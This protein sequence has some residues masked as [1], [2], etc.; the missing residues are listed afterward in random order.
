MISHI[1]PRPVTEFSYRFNDPDKAF[2]YMSFK[3]HNRE[4]DVPEILASWKAAGMEGFDVSGDEL[5]KSHARY[6]IGGKSNVE[7]ERVFRFGMRVDKGGVSPRR[8]YRKG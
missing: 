5:A 8:R 2:I 6:L 1:Y 3:V 7:N 4:R